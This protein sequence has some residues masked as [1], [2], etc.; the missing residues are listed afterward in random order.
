MQKRVVVGMLSLAAVGSGVL[1]ANADGIART[2]QSVPVQQSDALPAGLERLRA[3]YPTVQF[4]TY[5]DRVRAV[6]GTPMTEGATADE[7]AAA[8]WASYSDV[9]GIPGLSLNV[10][11][12]A[13]T[14]FAR[15][16]VFM[17]QQTLAGLPVEYTVGRILVNNQ[18]G[19]VVYAAGI[20][21]DPPTLGFGEMTVSAEDAILTAS[22]HEAAI[23]EDPRDPMV[24]WMAPE[25]VVYAGT[26]EEMGAGGFGEAVRAWKVTGD[27]NVL[28]HA[29]R[30]TFFV[31]ASSGQIVAVRN[32]ILHT[33]VSGTVQGMASPGTLPDMA[34][35]PPTMQNIP[36][37]RVSIT[38][39][40]NAFANRDGEFT[41]PN[42]GTAP[43]TV[44]TN[45]S[46]GMWVDV[47]SS[48]GAEMSLSQSVTPPGPANL[49]F[50]A[51][52]TALNTAQVNALIH[53]DLIH[54]FVKDRTTWTALDTVM[55]ANVNI[56]S[57]CNAFYNGSSINFYQ[58]G[59]GCNN[60]AYSSVVAHE[61]GHHIVNRLG[62]AQ[63]AFGEGFGDSCSVL[64]YNDP[65]IGRFFRTTGS[66]VRDYSPGIPDDP[67]PCDPGCNSQVHCCGEILG[68]MWEDIRAN[69]VTQYGLE[70]GL[71]L[72]RQLFVDWMQIS[73]G[74][75]GSNSAHPALVTEIL[76]ADDTDGDLAN[77]SPN[78][79]IICA[80]AGLHLINCP[81]L[82]LVTFEFPDGLPASI[83]PQ[84]AT[85]IRV[86]V[87]PLAGTPTPGTGTISYRISGGS[88]TTA[89]MTQGAPNNYTANLPLLTCGQRLD[90]YFTSGTSGGNVTSPGSAPTAFYSALSSYGLVENFADAFETSLGWTAGIA[91]DTATTG[92]W[93]RVNPNGTAAQPEDDHTPAPGTMCFVTGQ[94]SAGGA[95][96]ENDVDG[97]TTTLLSPVFNLSTAAEPTVEYWRWYS[98]TAGASPNADVFRVQITSNGTT[99]V[100]LETVGPTGDEVS[101][102]WF[103]RSF[104]VADFV[105]PSATVRVRFIAEDAGSG[106]IIEA[107][108]DDFRIYS[109]DC[110][111]PAS[112]PGDLDGDNDID[113]GDLSLLLS[114]FGGTGPVG[115]LDEDGDVDISDLAAIL[116]V[117]GT[118]CP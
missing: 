45:V 13:D 71:T 56:A 15:Q 17:Y 43:V 86:N 4:N 24:E 62:L 37:I 98:N 79:A 38:G 53:T 54:N 51:T 20:F 81:P 33:D 102:G 109:A 26:P 103:F 87:L 59:G 2:M 101:G 68:G 29:N 93:T 9:F 74:G 105:T 78:Y 100:P 83:A 5:L 84:T 52:P 82:S 39:G 50:N 7:A 6:Y 115:D 117:F 3:A 72:V 89:A 35:N 31:D 110:N 25:L 46:S 12:V 70:N 32:E 69:F 10:R 108:V 97:G 18:I 104:R 75:Q 34:S 1:M 80:A 60:T 23:G 36:E 64:L 88:W 66:P 44:T 113:I 58:I 22:L 61:Y 114:A 91:G 42:G 111:P 49:V 41:I 47:N 30:K 11:N 8:F 27:N 77:G 63:G 65:V 107:A 16:T 73:L 99:W 106:S 19:R 94:G 92:I 28:E 55:P 90:Y 21:A 48:A 95:V 57:T 85:P 112:C 116:S 118:P 14:N 76:V 96:G 67:Y 40:S